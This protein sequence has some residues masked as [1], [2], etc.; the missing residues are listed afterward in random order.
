M[1]YNTAQRQSDVGLTSTIHR[2]ARG[3]QWFR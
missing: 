1:Q 2:V 3:G